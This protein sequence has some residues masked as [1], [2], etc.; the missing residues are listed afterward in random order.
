[1][2]KSV[3]ELDE[4]KLHH[5]AKAKEQQDKETAKGVRLLYSRRHVEL[6]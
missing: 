3:F 2:S 6:S 1:M 4:D 5:Y